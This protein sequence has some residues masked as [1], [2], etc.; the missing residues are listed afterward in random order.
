MVLLSG[1]KAK[2]FDREVAVE[3]SR[4]EIR[5]A[6]PVSNTLTVENLCDTVTGLPRPFGT[7]LD[8]GTSELDLFVGANK[9][10]LEVRTDTVYRDSIVHRDKVVEKEKKVVVK[11]TDW[12]LVSILG[13]VLLLFIVF[14]GIPKWA[15]LAIGKL[16]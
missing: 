11:R 5:Y 9:M 3:T 8:T 13:S 2:E 4:T 12:R 16:V 15:N 6:M 1:C 7:R 14:P 10:V